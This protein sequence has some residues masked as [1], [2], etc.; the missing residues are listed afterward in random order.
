MIDFVK[1]ETV[2]ENILEKHKETRSDDYL[3]FLLVIK[4]M[5]PNLLNKTLDEV[6]RGHYKNGLPNWETVTRTRRKIQRNRPEL[7]DDRTILKRSDRQKEFENYAR[8]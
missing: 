2:V 3:L 4:R 6:F 8:T 1:V 5:K 7:C